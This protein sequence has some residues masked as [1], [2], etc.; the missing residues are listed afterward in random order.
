MSENDRFSFKGGAKPRSAK[1]AREKATTRPRGEQEK[2]LL[3]HEDSTPRRGDYD[4]T[5]MAVVG[6][7]L[8]V[9]MSTEFAREKIEISVWESRPAADNPI[10]RSR[11]KAEIAA[12]LVKEAGDRLD[13]AVRQYFPHMLED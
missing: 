8:T 10:D 1:G 5:P 2:T 13:A 7:S 9:G 4:P 6:A 3:D 11:V 12:D